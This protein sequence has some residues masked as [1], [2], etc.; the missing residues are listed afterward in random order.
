MQV[1]HFHWWQ[2]V[3]AVMW[4]LI[5]DLAAVETVSRQ[6]IPDWWLWMKAWR[7]AK[8]C[9]TLLME[10]GIFCPSMRKKSIREWLFWAD[11]IK[12][13]ISTTVLGYFLRFFRLWVQKMCLAC[14]LALWLANGLIRPFP[15]GR[16]CCWTKTIFWAHNLIL[17]PFDSCQWLRTKQFLLVL[18]CLMHLIQFWCAKS[19]SCT[20][21]AY[22]SAQFIFCSRQILNSSEPLEIVVLHMHF[23]YQFCIEFSPHMLNNRHR[24]NYRRAVSY[25]LIMI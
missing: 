3:R 25:K 15:T 8:K 13:P 12:R 7:E 11:L 5:S 1:I 10:K 19:S 20:R 21:S 23:H 24:A 6:M 9:V 2:S 4:K 16:A 18:L 14:N 17:S 22:I